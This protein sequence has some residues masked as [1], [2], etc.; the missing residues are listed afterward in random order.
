MS[1]IVV[2]GSTGHIGSFLVPRL[3]R[4]GH[5]VIGVSRGLRAPYVDDPAWREVRP[6]SLDREADPEGFPAAIAG[7]GADVVVDLTC[8]TPEQAAPL[9]EALRGRVELLAHCGTIWVHGPSTVVPTTEDD[10]RN[11]VGDYGTQKAA[12][13]DLL[14]AESARP[15]GLATTVLRPGHITGPG[16]PMINPVGNL[17]L[18]VWHALA[19]GERVAVPF[20][21]VPTL[22]HVHADDVAQAFA[23]AVERP[24]VVRGR[25]YNIVAAR[26]MTLRGL[27]EGVASWFGR[28]AVLEDVSLE[29]FRAGTT[30]E[31]ADATVE[32]ASR[33]HT[34]SIDRARQDLGYEPRFDSLGAIADALAWLAADGAV[35]LGDGGLDAVR[36]HAAPTV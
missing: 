34:M 25:V 10:P 16:W 22:N 31:H 13:E 20:L 9:V 6:V 1:T 14:L 5:S 2:I 21:G 7:L 18:D 15:D 17:D 28:S 33:S 8:F 23:A 30:V 36:E 27:A 24:T 11:P 29:E 3:V 35:D 4:A 32:H 12:I 19:T 26:S